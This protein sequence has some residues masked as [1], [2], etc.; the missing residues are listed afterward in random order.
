MEFDN[1]RLRKS[2]TRIKHYLNV[3]MGMIKQQ[4]YWQGRS[5]AEE[6]NQQWWKDTTNI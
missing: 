3:L 4:R 5:L 2:R 1:P 6:V